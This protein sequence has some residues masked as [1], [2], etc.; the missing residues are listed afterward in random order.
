MKR[1][2]VGLMVVGLLAACGQN[3]G[4]PAEDAASNNQ[5]DVDFVTGMIPHHQ[6]AIR[7]ASLAESRSE[8]AQV[9]ELATRIQQA[10]EPEIATMTGLLEDWGVEEGS[11]EAT[12]MP[13]MGGTSGGQMAQSPGGSGMMDEAD[14]AALEAARGAEFDR[15]FLESMI[16]HHQSAVEQA[17]KEL[18]NGQSEEAKALAGQIV[19]AQEAEIQEMRNLLETV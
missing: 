6:E 5:A 2:F 19:E 4:G 1:Q 18:E 8:N 7:M 9:K 10:Q 3:G 17:N 14:M 13:G 12:G 15:L 16:E 11:G